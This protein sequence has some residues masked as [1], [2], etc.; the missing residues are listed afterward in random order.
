MFYAYVL[1]SEKNG[2]LYY[3]STNDL[4]RRLSEHNSGIGGKYTS[5]NKPFK[6]IYYEA[7]IIYELARKAERFY[8]TGY[9][10]EVLKGKLEI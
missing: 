2:K 1:K 5:D 3:G 7:Y 4:K 8:K 10:R 9:G 6:L